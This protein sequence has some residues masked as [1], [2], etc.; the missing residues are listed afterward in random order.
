LI[1]FNTHGRETVYK[2]TLPTQILFEMKRMP[3]IENGERRSEEVEKG[4]GGE[5]YV[6]A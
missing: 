4:E 3:T 6:Q 1:T 2:A 5:R